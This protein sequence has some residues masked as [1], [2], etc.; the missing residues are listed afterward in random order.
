MKLVRFENGTYGVTRYRWIWR[1]FLDLTR[2]SDDE[3]K[4]YWPS[5]SIEVER[6]CQGTKE[7]ALK[8]L[9]GFHSQAPRVKFDIIE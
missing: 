8:R 1:G 9:R 4:C 7:A 5:S 2:P 6:C 3:D